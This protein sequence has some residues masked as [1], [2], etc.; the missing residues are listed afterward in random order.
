MATYEKPIA[1]LAA[2]F[3]LANMGYGFF[4]AGNATVKT[5]VDFSISALYYPKIMLPNT[6]ITTRAIISNEG[7]LSASFVTYDYRIFDER[8]AETYRSPDGSYIQVLPA[9]KEVSKY[10]NTVMFSKA[11]K[12]KVRVT[13]DSE[14]QFDEIN[15]NNNVYETT[16]TVTD[17]LPK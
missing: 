14:K 4:G 11:G 7:V 10:I 6:H 12:Y 1:A 15:E 9:D 3:L 8:G 13:I 2:V 16:I 17:S 5:P